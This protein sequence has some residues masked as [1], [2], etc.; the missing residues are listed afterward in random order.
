M[1]AWTARISS[2]PWEGNP[3]A[4]RANP[5]ISSKY[6]NEGLSPSQVNCSGGRRTALV[7]EPGCNCRALAR[8]PIF[9]RGECYIEEILEELPAAFRLGLAGM[10]SVEVCLFGGWDAI[11]T[12]LI[13]L[14]AIDFV[15]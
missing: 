3:V 5:G 1:N 10:V 7:F 8:G 14:I 2:R 13:A 9:Y 4:P 6:R 15:T 12:A 11:L